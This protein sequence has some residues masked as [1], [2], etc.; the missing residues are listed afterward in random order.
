MH[1]MIAGVL[2]KDDESVID[3]INGKKN[4]NRKSNLKITTTSS[5]NQKRVL[6]KNRFS[7]VGVYKRKNRWVSDIRHKNGSRYSKYFKHDYEAARFYDEKMIEI[8]GH[9]A[10]T[11]KKILEELL[12]KV[13]GT[14]E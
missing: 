4:D 3:H 11:N 9:N 10:L 1:R 14:I 5:N 6:N 12:A 7:F 2:L 8:H 13:S